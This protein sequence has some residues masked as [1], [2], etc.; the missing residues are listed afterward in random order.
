MQEKSWI[1]LLVSEHLNCWIVDIKTGI[2][3]S[4]DLWTKRRKWL[5]QWRSPCLQIL[6]K[7]CLL[8]IQSFTLKIWGKAR[9]FK[10]FFILQGKYM[11]SVL[12]SVDP[13]LRLQFIVI[14][15]QVVMPIKKKK[16]SLLTLLVILLHFSHSFCS[17]LQ[18]WL[19]HFLY[20][21]VNG[22]RN[23]KPLNGFCLY[24]N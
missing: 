4:S 20:E 18:L 5:S 22:W 9:F 24:R 15:F 6:S 12:T 11:Y 16:S 14:V 2:F 21:R 10:S 8:P 7:R 13:V 19:C 17:P 3:L 1:S 23:E